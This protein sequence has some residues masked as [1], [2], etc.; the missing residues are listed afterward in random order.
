[1]IFCFLLKAFELSPIIKKVRR[2]TEEFPQIRL[3]NP[4]N[5]SVLLTAATAAV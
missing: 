5:A 4:R 2:N 3:F 1:M